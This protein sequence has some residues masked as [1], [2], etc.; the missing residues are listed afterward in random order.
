MTICVCLVISAALF[1]FEVLEMISDERDAH[2]K[3][4]W[5]W[6]TCWFWIYTVFVVIVVLILR[7]DEK[8]DMLG[9][10]QEVLD[11]TLTEM[12]TDMGDEMDIDSSIVDGIELHQFDDSSMNQSN[13]THNTEPGLSIFSERSQE[14]EMSMEEFKEMKR[15]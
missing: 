1:V 14:P 8:A 11:E 5:A 3:V 7:P 13:P 6:E 15:S 2:W 12:P 9:Q 4:Q 10:M